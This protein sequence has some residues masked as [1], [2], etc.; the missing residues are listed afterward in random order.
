MISRK[1]IV[2]MLLLLGNGLSL[3]AWA[4]IYAL[5]DADGAISLSNVPTDERY[6]VLIAA[7]QQTVAAA[8]PAAAPS[9]AA[10]WVPAALVAWASTA[11]PATAVRVAAASADAVAVACGSAVGVNRSAGTT[12]VRVWLP[13]WPACVSM[14]WTACPSCTTRQAVASCSM[15]SRGSRS[16]E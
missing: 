6:T 12:N 7:P 15:T 2:N 8:V 13:L 4:D 16:H 5:T 3:P 9:V 1:L 11:A 10:I 14:A